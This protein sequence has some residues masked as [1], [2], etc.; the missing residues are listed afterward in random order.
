MYAVVRSGGRSYRVEEGAL[1]TVGRR[2]GD[3]G[4]TI[5]FDDVLLVADGVRI[6]AGTPH[7]SDA[8]VSAEIVG[9]G[10]GRKIRVFKYKNK[11][12]SR[13]TRGHRQDET[14]L[15]ITKI[16]ARPATDETAPASGSG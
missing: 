10:R 12:R 6:R 3:V 16:E 5:T 15:R 4:S 11:T 7:L 8:K 9:H 1:V 13:K 14:T 2:A